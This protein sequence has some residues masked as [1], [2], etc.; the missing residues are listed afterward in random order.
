MIDRKPLDSLHNAL[1]DRK[2]ARAGAAKRRAAEVA[3]KAREDLELI[4]GEQHRLRA[5]FYAR[6]EARND[7]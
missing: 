7:A 1:E 4:R 5:E 2:K 6:R 3:A